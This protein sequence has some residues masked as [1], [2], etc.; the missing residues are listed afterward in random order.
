MTAR[1]IRS[2][3]L[4]G[5]RNAGAR[6]ASIPSPH[7]E[8]SVRFAIGAVLT[9]AMLATGCY[10]QRSS[11]GGQQASFEPP[12][13]L[14]VRDVAVPEGYRIEVV[15]AGLTFPTG[16]AFDDQ[17]RVHVIEAGYVYGEKWAVPRLLRIDAGGVATTVASGAKNGPWNGVVFHRG[18]FYV[19]EGGQLEGGR[20]LRIS[21]EGRITPLVEDL[22]SLGDHHTNGPAIGPDGA[23]YFGQGVAT[24]SA[25]VGED[26]W[27]FGWLQRHPEVHDIPCRDV[28]LAGRNFESPNPMTS[29]RDDR[30]STGAF[31]RFGTASTPGQVVAG[32]VP[33]SGAIMKIPI[34][35]GRPELVAWGLRNPFGLAFDPDGRLFVT[36]NGYDDRGSRPVWGSGD[37]LWAITPGAWYGWPDWSGADPLTRDDFD[38]P[39]KPAPE[40]LLE[41]APGTPPAPVAIFGVHSSANGF[42]FSRGERFGHAG[43]AFVA[44]LGDMTPGVGKLLSPVGFKVVRVDVATGAI[45]DF[46]VNRGKVN[47]PASKLGHAGLERPVAVRFD[48]AGGALY[49]VDFGVMTAGEKGPVAHEGTGALWRITRADASTAQ[50]GGR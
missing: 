21:P 2:G 28:T 25:V 22:P 44:L 49:V 18:A 37:L 39:G 26:N 7:E 9:A 40:P 32:R 1:F 11:S 13:R 15:A 45:Q 43:E 20:I 31:M 17:G 29:D 16:V 5:D 34:G 23:L 6:G 35:G 48:P 36:D 12:R 14:E 4:R 47:G 30:A 8:A 41:P 19:S 33:C 50:R 10:A 42:D 3:D 27:T 24:N 46:A 38:P